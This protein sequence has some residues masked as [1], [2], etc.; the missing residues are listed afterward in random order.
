MKTSLGDFEAEAQRQASPAPLHLVVCAPIG[1]CLKEEPP[2]DGVYLDMG[3][4]ITAI[5]MCALPI[6]LY[7]FI[8]LYILYT[9]DLFFVAYVS[10]YLLYSFCISLLVSLKGA[11]D[12]GLGVNLHFE[13]ADQNQI[14]QEVLG[15]E[16]PEDRFG[17]SFAVGFKRITL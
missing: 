7:L 13:L 2:V 4:A 9:L 15:T 10:L 1:P 3:S 8:Q 11:Q 16:F 6:A 14:Y 5:S 12:C 17:R